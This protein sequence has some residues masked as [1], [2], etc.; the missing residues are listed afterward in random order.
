MYR[1]GPDDGTLSVRT[2]R[3]GAA[4]KAGHNLLIHVT[5]WEATI[6]LGEETSIVL[7]AD[8]GS[9]RVREGTGGMQALQDE[10]RANIEQTIDDE[11]LEGQPITFRSSAVEPA[12]DAAGLS[13]HGELTLLGA[14]RPLTFDVAMTAHGELRAVAVV[15][16]TDWGMKPYSGLFGALKVV[17][18]VEVGIEAT[19]P[20]PQSL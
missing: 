4:A 19:L 5:S 11:V 1:L 7:E 20:P 13:V 17:D 12:G 8:G 6:E 15:K 2:K 10:D 3:T 16:Q 9:L 14:T 18:E